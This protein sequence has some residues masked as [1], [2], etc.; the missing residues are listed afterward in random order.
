MTTD[1][2]AGCDVGCGKHEV[3]TDR[4]ILYTPTVLDLAAGNASGSDPEAQRWL[5]FAQEG[6]VAEPQRGELLSGSPGRGEFRDLSHLFPDSF[7]LV[8]VDPRR[9]RHLGMVAIEL[10]STGRY[11]TGGWLAPGFRGRGLGVELFA[12]ATE[13]AHEHLGIVEL[14]AGT[15]IANIASRRALVCAG[16]AL[17]NGPATHTQMNGQVISACWY[18][19]KARSAKRCAVDDAD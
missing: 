12:A 5:G 18:R 13:L 4:L 19:H 15:D 11:Q 7:A 1:V 10:D 8:A 14:Y 17:T 3:L 16:F 2:T 9:S 6:I